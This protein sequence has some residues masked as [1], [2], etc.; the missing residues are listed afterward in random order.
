MEQGGAEGC[1]P[2]STAVPVEVQPFRS[3]MVQHVFF[4]CSHG[5]RAEA[6]ERLEGSEPASAR[7]PG[8]HARLLIRLKSSELHGLQGHQVSS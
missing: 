4:W 7:L 2:A 3:L 5:G 8:L 6:I 1:G